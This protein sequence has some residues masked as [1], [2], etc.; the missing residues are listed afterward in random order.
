MQDE[1]NSKLSELIDHELSVEEALGLMDSINDIPE[2]ED[3]LH[4]Y[5]AVSQVIKTDSFLNADVD[6]VNRVKKEVALEPLYLL[7]V[8]QRQ[9]RNYQIISALAASVAIMAIF[10]YGGMSQPIE[11]DSPLLK[12]AAKTSLQKVKPDS[13][14]QDST[15]NKFNDYLEAHRG[16]L[17]MA[18]SPGYQSY[19]R[20]ADYGQE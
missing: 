14:G 10:I 3:K 17:Y 4:R 12:L 8:K 13:G 11:D 16:S 2:H 9:T 20:L 5:R 1:L 7:P 19:V 6:F 15:N 18:G